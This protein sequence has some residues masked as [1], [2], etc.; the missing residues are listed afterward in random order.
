MWRLAVT[1]GPKLQSGS[2]NPNL[3][4]HDG[5]IILLTLTCDTIMFQGCARKHPVDCHI[6]FLIQITVS[7]NCFSS[8][9]NRQFDA[10]L[11]SNLTLCHHCHK[12]YL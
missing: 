8:V 3:H 5:M 9:Y 7:N 11:K 2:R 10:F 4:Q 12:K 1:E 6:M